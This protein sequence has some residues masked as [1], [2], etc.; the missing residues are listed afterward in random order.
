MAVQLHGLNVRVHLHSISKEEAI[1]QSS[2]GCRDYCYWF[3]PV[4][5][6]IPGLHHIPQDGVVEKIRENSDHLR[7]VVW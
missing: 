4:K 3:H 6:A 1:L 7:V 5:Q 2:A